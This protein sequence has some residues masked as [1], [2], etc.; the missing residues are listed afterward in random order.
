M[1]TLQP[2]FPPQSICPPFNPPSFQAS[3]FT[4]RRMKYTYR[5]ATPDDAAACITLRGQTRENA[6]SRDELQAL[7]ITEA[8]WS[9]GIRM[10][11]L[12]GVV[13][14][15]EGTMAGYC[16]ADR[17]SGEILVLALLP[18]HEG[19]GVGRALLAQVVEGLRQ[20]GIGRIH[21]ACSADPKV[22]SHGFYRRMGLR[23]TGEIDSWGDEIL[24]LPAQQELRLADALPVPANGLQIRRAT[25]KDAEDI[26]RILWNTYETTWKPE[27]TATAI[28]RF[29]SSGNTARYVDTRLR[30]MR[31]AESYG[32]IVGFVDWER[33]FIDA[34]H[35]S[36]LH[37]HQGVGSHLLAF[38]ET[39]IAAAGHTGVQL[40]TD[41]FNRQARG[42]YQRHGYQETGYCPDEEWHSGFTTVKMAKT[43]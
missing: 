15:Q 31:V 43:F 41:T 22:R 37:Q 20:R 14:C 42:F 25:A 34:L 18:A 4:F 10:G 29:E 3:P 38:A 9:E 6:F 24:E 33:D 1:C 35:V 28:A 36:P 39:W 17:D 12:P 27:L 16:F 30:A 2:L 23:A 8:S 21:L 19:Q 7:G 32:T 40:E 5:P 26:R 11:S 13:A